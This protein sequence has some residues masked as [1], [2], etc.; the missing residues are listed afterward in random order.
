MAEQPTPPQPQDFHIVVV[1]DEPNIRDVLFELISG[2]GYRV[3]SAKSGRDA[4]GILQE[5]QADLVITDLMMPDLNGW[6]L[7]KQVKE[8]YSK[9]A[10][11]ILTGYM[12][13]EGE[14]ILTNNEIDGY[15]TKPLEQV[16]FVEQ[17]EH[18]IARKKG[19]E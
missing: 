16:S 7:L 11:V 2:Y 5:D 12:S 9:T 19:E 13:E 14:E 3:S 18:L 15:L 17:V 6:Q 8:Q 10:V 1:D 4:L